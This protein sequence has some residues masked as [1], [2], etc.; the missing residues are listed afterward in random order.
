[1]KKLIITFL[2]SSFYLSSFSQQQHVVDG[3]VLDE[4]NIIKDKETINKILID[5]ENK[6]KTGVQILVATTSD[7]KGIEPYEYTT[8]LG[9]EIGVGQAGSNNGIIIL[10]APN[11]RKWFIATGYGMESIITDFDCKQIGEESIIKSEFKEGNYDPSILRIIDRIHQKVGTMSKADRENWLRQEQEAQKLRNEK[12]WET[13]KTVIWNIFLVSVIIGIILFAIKKFVDFKKHRKNI[14]DLKEKF[15]DLIKDIDDQINSRTNI[16]GM[17]YK[18]LKEHVLEASKKLTI[19]TSKITMSLVEITIYAFM[20]HLKQLNKKHAM[21]IDS[22]HP[23]PYSKE[24]L[25]SLQNFKQ[26]KD[27]LNLNNNLTETSSIDDI[28]NFLRDRTYKIDAFK[29]LK[30]KLASINEFKKLNQYIAIPSVQQAIDY[31]DER[32]K[33]NSLINSD[34][35]YSLITTAKDDINLWKTLNHFLFTPLPIN[36]VETYYDQL[37]I[38]ENEYNNIISLK[39]EELISIN[40]FNSTTKIIDNFNNLERLYLNVK[41]K[42][43]A[44]SSKINSLLANYEFYIK[45]QNRF[46][47]LQ[48]SLKTTYKQHQSETPASYSSQYNTLLALAF[49]LENNK[50][51]DDFISKLKK[52]ILEIEEEKKRK[53]RKKEQDEEDDRRRNSYSSSYSSIGSSYSSSSSSSSSSD[54]GGGSFGGGGG[55]GDW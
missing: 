41:N 11:D 30:S 4:A 54:F 19:T 44:L 48:S 32:L 21:L 5:Q 22:K 24:E 7:L 27:L 3:R 18:A 8:K 51:I 50:K 1:M 49:S 35:V 52:E 26:A 53:K 10:I 13:T 29:E 42:Q 9:N 37:K 55:G 40:E 31:I 12:A 6:Y 46:T 38:Y 39:S 45:E 34:N 33:M 23:L 20:E 28:N 47:S 2:L 17:E 14:L 43:E 25:E 36:K 16:T 15:Y